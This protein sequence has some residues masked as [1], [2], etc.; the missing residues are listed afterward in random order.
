MPKNKRSEYLS[1]SDVVKGCVVSLAK[2]AS[3]QGPQAVK[4]LPLTESEQGIVKYHA[5]YCYSHFQK[6]YR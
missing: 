3:S 6:D 5:S 1:S 2:Q 4:V